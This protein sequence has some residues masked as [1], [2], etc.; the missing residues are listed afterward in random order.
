MTS[1]VFSLGIALL[2]FGGAAAR[3]GDYVR[4]MGKVIDPRL[5][6]LLG[7]E[8]IGISS[9]TTLWRPIGKNKLDIKLHVT[10]PGK[11]ETSVWVSCYYK[12]ST[13]IQ[14]FGCTRYHV[15]STFVHSC[16]NA[17]VPEGLSSADLLKAFAN[18][19]FTGTTEEWRCDE[20]DSRGPPA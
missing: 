18:F 6:S 10:M 19:T 16:D 4:E 2:L 8:R 14:D 11:P 1:R 3:A 5:L 9:I 13:R 20:N 17:W 15:G 12:Y 7:P